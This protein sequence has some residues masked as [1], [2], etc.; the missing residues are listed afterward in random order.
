MLSKLNPVRLLMA[1]RR[2]ANEER[3]T[4]T[5]TMMMMMI[6]AQGANSG[7][8]SSPF[9]LLILSSLARRLSLTE[10]HVRAAS[11]GNT[12]IMLCSA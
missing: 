1:D 7:V 10:R 6:V 8:S 4:T 3:G 12:K 9:S 5:T 2:S 11:I